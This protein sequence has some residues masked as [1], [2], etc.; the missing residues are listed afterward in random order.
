MRQFALIAVLLL[1]AVFMNHA[2]ARE[3]KP[4]AGWGVAGDIDKAIEHA[5]ENGL[6][7]VFVQTFNE[8]TCP[9]CINATTQMVRHRPFGNM[10]RLMV[11]QGESHAAFRQLQQQV[12]DNGRYLPR[13]YIADADLN[14]IYFVRYED[15]ST[16]LN[17]A[18]NV[19]NQL[20]SWR[21]SVPRRLAQA[22]THATRGNFY[23][24]LDII[25]KIAAEDSEVTQRLEAMQ[26]GGQQQAQQ[27]SQDAEGQA[28]PRPGKFFP[29]LL[30]ESREKFEQ[31]ADDLL[32]EAR[33]A[34]E[35]ENWAV[36]RRV[37]TPMSRDRSDLPQIAEAG[38][39]L[40]QVEAAQ[41]QARS[42]Q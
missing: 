14:L 30:S 5:K 4:P 42:Q 3:I 9:L 41:S 2:D 7:L 19:T 8:T 26:R 16:A 11:Y 23:Q 34:I 1:V 24:A 33:K 15:V 36:A 29:D 6:P 32:A 21:N 37:L 38:E 25:E 10:V 12:A 13:L 22:Q 27:G 35:E 31:I 17:E 40:K 20:M 39:L 18:S 28:A